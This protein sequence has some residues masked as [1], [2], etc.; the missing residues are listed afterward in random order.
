MFKILML[1]SLACLIICNEATQEKVKTEEEDDEK[2]DPLYFENF[3]YVE[4]L[5]NLSF[6]IFVKKQQYAI[7]YFYIPGCQRC[8]EFSPHFNSAAESIKTNSRDNNVIAFGKINCNVETELC[9][10]Y[11][12]RRYPTV[13][14]FKSKDPEKYEYHEGEK[15]RVPIERELRRMIDSVTLEMKSIDHIEE[16]REFQEAMIIFVGKRDTEHYK[17]FVKEAEK[18]VYDG[19]YFAHCGFE[20]CSKYLKANEGDVVIIKDFDEKHNVLHPG[21]TAEEFKHF[22]EQ[23][24]YPDV[25]EFSEITY[26]MTFDRLITSLYLFRDKTTAQAEEQFAILKKISPEFK[27]KIKFSILDITSPVENI[28]ANHF[29]ITASDLPLAII[30]EP[31]KVR[32]LQYRLKEITENSLR[33][34]VNGYLNKTIEP[35]LKSE[36]PLKE[37]NGFDEHGI[38][39]LTGQEF[40]QVVND[41]SKDVLVMFYTDECV[42]CQDHYPKYHDLAKTLTKNNPNILFSKLNYTKNETKKIYTD[43]YPAFFLWPADN[44][45]EL[46]FEEEITLN[47]LI[48]FAIANASNPLHIND[49]L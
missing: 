35:T 49:D 15:S 32:I 37:N 21:F 25:H 22:V 3:R 26:F 19:T 1:C 16:I 4:N 23:K 29:G 6:N 7:A 8:S 46:R 48:N 41:S 34:F 9:Q 5:N 36:Q 13:L 31:G 17:E 10:N 40:D 42:H 14:Y 43:R 44:K 45:S 11:E 18:K 12:V 28:I 33:S 27:T 47:N 39:Y 38:K 2:V 24:Y 30:F 20:G